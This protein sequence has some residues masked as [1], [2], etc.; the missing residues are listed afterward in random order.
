MLRSVYLH[1][2]KKDI[3]T[4]A[5]I[6]A[7]LTSLYIGLVVSFLFYAPRYFHLVD[8]PDTVFAP[9]IML[10]LFVFSAAI[11]GT[12]VLGR[13]ILW[14]M[15]GNKKDAIALFLYTLGVFFVILLIS[16]VILVMTA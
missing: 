2:M 11:T 9:I 8:K 15:N 1:Y 12:L 3:A 10:M 14:Y 6:N 7:I 16:F 4:Y 13:P 5:F